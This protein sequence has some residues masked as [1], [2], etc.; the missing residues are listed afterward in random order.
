[1]Q[2]SVADVDPAELDAEMTVIDVN[3]GVLPDFLRR[4][5]QLA[6][7]ARNVAEQRRAAVARML[8]ARGVTQVRVGSSEEVPRALMRALER[9]SHRK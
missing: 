6:K 1:M 2:I 9:S 3:E 7:E 4:D 5:E 8:D